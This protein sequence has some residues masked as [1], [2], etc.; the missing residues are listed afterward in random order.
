MKGIEFYPMS[1]RPKPSK[2]VSRWSETVLVYEEEHNFQDFGYFDFEK[3]EWHI[4]G[5]DSM[6]LKC[7]CNIPQPKKENIEK[8]KPTT[9]FGYRP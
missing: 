5:T 3:D 6:K 2:D 9:H 1:H 7:W 8:F 4:L